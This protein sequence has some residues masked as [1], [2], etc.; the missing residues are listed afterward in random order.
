MANS[1]ALFGAGFLLCV[2]W[3]DLK[4]D[5]LVWRLDG[6][7]P[8]EVLAAVAAYYNRVVPTD[9][10]RVPL[11]AFVMIATIVATIWQILRGELPLPYRILVPALAWP[12]ILLAMF[13]IVPSAAK[14]GKRS[15]TPVEQSSIARGVF[16]GHIFCFVSIALF[17]LMQ[18]WIGYRI[19]GN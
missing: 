5:S 18:F 11:I 9:L 12:P 10:R 3:I 6:T 16:R 15:G 8:E 7:L 14:L 2:L 19:A 13:W 4:F 17:G 1:V